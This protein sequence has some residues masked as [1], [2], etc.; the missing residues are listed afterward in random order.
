MPDDSVFEDCTTGTFYGF[1]DDKNNEFHPGDTFTIQWGAY[2]DYTPLNITLARLGGSLV[3]DIVEFG[4]FSDSSSLYRSYSPS[5]N[6]TLEQYN[7]TIPA[8]FDTTNPTFNLALMNATQERGT[9]GNALSGFL[10]WSPIFYIRD[11]ASATSTGT[12][13]TSAIPTSSVSHTLSP[14]A[15]TGSSDSPDDLST[16]AKA[17]IGVGVSI[18][19]LLVLGLL[20]FVL[21]RRFIRR[22]P[23][24]SQA[25]TVIPIE[26]EPLG[27]PEL[28]AYLVHE[29]DAGAPHARLPELD[30]ER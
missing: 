2:D 20:A 4:I 25:T 14:T 18:T 9:D 16:G 30:S 23:A 3:N 26:E 21:R 7:W 1:T 5:P 19:G 11:K 24:S 29:M 15:I 22:Q 10:A 28:S 12:V 6:C 13:S 8:N 17:G 27:K